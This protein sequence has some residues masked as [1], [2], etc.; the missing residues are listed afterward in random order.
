MESERRDRWLASRVF[1]SLN[2]S[3]LVPLNFSNLNIIISVKPWKHVLYTNFLL[4]VDLFSSF[5]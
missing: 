1:G 3:R 2:D 4:H 5:G